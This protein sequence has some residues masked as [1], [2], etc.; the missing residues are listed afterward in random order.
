MAD[1]IS[2]DIV[3]APFVKWADERE[4]RMRKAAMWTVREGGRVVKLAARAK[5]PVLKDRSA[6]H[7]RTW[8]KGG[9]GG[10]SRPVAGLLRNSISPARRLTEVGP[11]WQLKVGPRG[12][13]VHLYAQKE[14]QR[15]H[16]MQAGYAAAQV[17][18]VAA[19]QQAYDRAWKGI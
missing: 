16:F 13:R 4:V 18:M 17:M 10:G 19:S 14:E 5:A 11:Y 7:Y 3:T 15:A 12:P 6:V 8:K 1:S 9:G 2:F